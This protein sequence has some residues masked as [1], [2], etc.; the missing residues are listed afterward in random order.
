M[1]PD[2]ILL[3]M[4]S[5]MGSIMMTWTYVLIKQAKKKNKKQQEEIIKNQQ[6]QQEQERP[7]K[8]SGKKFKVNILS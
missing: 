5:S 8:M 7:K 3:K 2:L 1:F 6:M 4:A